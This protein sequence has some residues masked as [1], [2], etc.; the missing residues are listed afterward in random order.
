MANTSEGIWII[1][2]LFLRATVGVKM[3]EFSGFFLFFV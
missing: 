3:D 1:D 2:R